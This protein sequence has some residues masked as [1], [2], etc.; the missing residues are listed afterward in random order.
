LPN[1]PLLYDRLTQ[2]LAH[3]RRTRCVI[4]VIFLDLDHFKRVNDTLGHGPG[5][6]LL[7]EVASRLKETLRTDDSVGRLG[8][9]EFALIL[10]DLTGPDD[11]SLAMQKVMHALELPFDL[12][13]HE[14]FITASAGIALS[15]QDGVDPD[16]LIKKADT[17]MYRAK[18][19]GRTNYQF[20]KS[21]MNDR[22][23]ERMS[24]DAHLRRAL[25]R[26][27]FVLHYQ[28]KVE[29][30]SGQITGLEALIRWQHAEYGLVAPGRFISI[31]E[32]NGLIVQVG[33]WVLGE[34][35]RQLDLWS[36]NQLPALRMAL[37]LSGR[38][39]QQR[40]LETAIQRIV[41][42]SSVDPRLIELEITESVLMRDPEQAARI[43]RRLKDMGIRL[44]V[45]DFGT[46]YSSL[47]YL[48]SFPLDALKIDRSFVKD[49]VSDSDDAAIVQA[50]IALARSLKL[51]TIA[52]GVE[53][54]SQLA[55][56]KA[57]GCDEYQGYYFSHPLPADQM[58]QLLES[59]R[60]SA[61]KQ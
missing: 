60:D 16:T 48:K 31:L 28:P 61:A 12:D 2:A 6:R 46:G 42:E 51:R 36:N 13:G 26:K 14:V 30:A 27:E 20:Y 3:S 37:N 4:A 19:M 33:E 45:D 49:L 5:D 15:P 21:E 29:L 53:E 50:I 52:E 25:E 41:F 57:F 47:S 58:A 24:L 56:L 32:D 54:L 43:L 17:A 11:V 22:S 34:A 10:S 38:Q 23:L 40:G 59:K 8:G 35:C 39:L 1:R 55:L 44:S 18:Q 7:Q 9:D